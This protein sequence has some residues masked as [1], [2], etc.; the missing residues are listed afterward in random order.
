MKLPMRIDKPDKA[1][2]PL[3]SPQDL[4]DRVSGLNGLELRLQIVGNQVLVYCGSGG[5]SLDAAVAA[6]QSG[7]DALSPTLPPAAEASISNPM[8]TGYLSVDG[9]IAFA[10]SVLNGPAAGAAAASPA[11][12]DA[13]PIVAS[14]GVSGAAMTLE[15]DVPVSAI[16]QI[17]GA[18]SQLNGAPDTPAEEACQLIQSTLA[19]GSFVGPNKHGVLYRD[20]VNLQMTAIAVLSNDGKDAAVSAKALN[21][22]SAAIDQAI[23]RAENIAGRSTETPQSK[24]KCR[25]LE[26]KLKEIQINAR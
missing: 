3:S 23:S 13:A 14:A 16:A 8:A 19:D 26:D 25:Q 10:Q 17:E 9:C 7:S 11:T 22:F 24:A 15:L 4:L 2:N 1:L 6:A 12:A 21:A 5:A 18:A 20:L